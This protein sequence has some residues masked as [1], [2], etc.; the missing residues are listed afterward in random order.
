MASNTYTQQFADG[1]SQ[2][3]RRG[4]KQGR[5]KS[6]EVDKAVCVSLAPS[7]LL[8]IDRK[9]KQM[10]MSRSAYLELAGVLFTI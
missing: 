3:Y 8:V 10:N 9:A 7:S 2:L 5:P 4:T 1:T 6:L